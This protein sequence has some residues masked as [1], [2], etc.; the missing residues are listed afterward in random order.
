VAR[1]DP[2]ADPRSHQ[3]HG[4]SGSRPYT[5]GLADDLTA[6]S[7]ALPSHVQRHAEREDNEQ[8]HERCRLMDECR[9]NERDQDDK[10]GDNG[11]PQEERVGTGVSVY[12]NMT[13]ADKPEHEQRD[14]AADGGDST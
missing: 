9:E 4:L 8:R 13:D 2:L 7:A 11:H 3:P 1:C 14:G 10:R 6:V 12:S 5:G